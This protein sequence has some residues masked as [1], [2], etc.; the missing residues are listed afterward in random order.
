M[1]VYQLNY[2]LLKRKWDVWHSVSTALNINISITIRFPYRCF[3]QCHINGVFYMFVYLQY[4]MIITMLS[5]KYYVR[6]VYRSNI[7]LFFSQTDHLLSTLVSTQYWK[8]ILNTFFRR[9]A[10][11]AHLRVRTYHDN[12]LKI[13]T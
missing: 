13:F 6:V 12:K 7:L 5:N 4:F 10:P 11:K 8:Q 9:E 2:F 1:F 3:L